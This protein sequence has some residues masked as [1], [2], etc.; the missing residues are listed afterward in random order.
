MNDNKALLWEG[1]TKSPLPP[2]GGEGLGEWGESVDAPNS[3]HPSPLPEGEG[4][5]NNS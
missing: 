3:P 1:Q 2:A 5:E 4:T